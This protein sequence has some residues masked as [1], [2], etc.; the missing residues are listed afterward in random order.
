MTASN[1]DVPPWLSSA[2]RCWT[3]R[4]QAMAD[5]KAQC[6]GAYMRCL[7]NAGQARLHHLQG[8]VY[9]PNPGYRGGCV[10]GLHLRANFC[11]SAICSG[12]ILSAVSF[13]N[14]SAKELPCAA[15]RLNHMYAL[16]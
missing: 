4:E 14:I 11:A 15:A 5:F 16:T 9:P 10:V 8:S 2:R 12:V 13:R 3:S 1:F 6:V 7:G